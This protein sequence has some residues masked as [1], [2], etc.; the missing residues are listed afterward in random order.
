MAFVPSAMERARPCV[1]AG[2][3]DKHGLLWQEDSMN[4]GT[5]PVQVWVPLLAWGHG[6]RAPQSTA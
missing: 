5:Q 3:H 2:R 4:V 1:A 6:S